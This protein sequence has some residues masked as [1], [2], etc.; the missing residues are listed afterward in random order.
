[1][2]GKARGMFVRKTSKEG[3]PNELADF[4]IILSS[5]ILKD[6][7]KLFAETLLH[8]VL[9]AYTTGLGFIADYKTINPG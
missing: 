8:E 2:G 1:M 3:Q 6:N 7:P 4:K 9:H 5:D